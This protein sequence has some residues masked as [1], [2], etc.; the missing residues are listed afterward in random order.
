MTTAPDPAGRD[1]FAQFDAAAREHDAVN[2]YLL[3]LV[4]AWFYPFVVSR[5]TGCAESDIP[6]LAEARMRYWG[7]GPSVRLISRSAFGRYDTQALVAVGEE[8][9][10]VVF[11]GSEHP[12]RVPRRFVNAMRDWLATDAD[13]AMIAVTDFG[14]EVDV[15]RGFFRGFM[16][17]AEE[18]ESAVRE[19]VAQGRR[20]WIAGHSLGGA[21]ATLA[22]PW[23]CARSVRVEGAY[24]FGAPRVGGVRF[25][26][27][28]RSLPIGGL[29]RYIHVGD[30]IPRLPPMLMKYRHVVTPHVIHEDGS[31]VLADA[32]YE[33]STARLRH[34]YPQRY[35]EA[36]YGALTDEQKSLMP[37]PPSH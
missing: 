37:P 15:H 16:A 13:I 29:H 34:H 14:P 17:V 24:T 8:I 32:D 20:L 36:L 18:I 26:D 5:Y 11:R 27:L 23:L 3:S 35:C 25:A 22:V 21:L 2:A 31:I 12:V 28:F 4:S 30:P 33:E 19:P 10:L 7:F 1:C 6:A 9:V